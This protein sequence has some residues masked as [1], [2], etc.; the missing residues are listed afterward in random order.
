M[1]TNINIGKTT[2]CPIIL[3]ASV[4]VS[5]SGSGVVSTSSSSGG[6]DGGGGG[7]DGGGAAAPLHLSEDP[8]VQEQPLLL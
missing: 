7:G 4:D 2:S 6:A 8:P 1:C 5:G 3:H